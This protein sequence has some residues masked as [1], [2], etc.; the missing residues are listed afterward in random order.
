MTQYM[1]MPELVGARVVLRAPR[2]EDA[3]DLFATV[4]A[5][6]EVTEFLSWTPHRNVDE[7]RR[8]IRELFNVGDDHTWV[9]VLR[10]SGEVVGEIG[11][12]QLQRHAVSIGYCLGRKWWGRGLMSEAVSVLLQQLQRDSSVFRA[13]AACHVD[14]VG[15][16]KVL[17]RC[18][19]AFEGRLVRYL[20]FPNLSPEPQDCLLYARALR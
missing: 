17:E 14:N 10:D 19:L 11:Y 13:S 4:T 1:E 5:D 2:I 8:V 15:S 20:V 16:A 6:P 18:G 9:V 12:R 3:E 7:T